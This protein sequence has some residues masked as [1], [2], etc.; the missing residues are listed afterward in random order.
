MAYR[1]AIKGMVC[2]RCDLAL[3]ELAEATGAHVLDSGRGYVDFAERLSTEAERAFER[4][5]EGI[6]F[7]ILRSETEEVAEAVEQ[8]L[9]ELVRERPS[10]NSASDLSRALSPKLDLPFARAAALYQS[11]R[12]QTPFER[13]TELRMQ[14]ATER[15]REGRMQ[16]S[17]VGY[18]LGY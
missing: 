12:S 14:W 7:S 16:V 6:R 13:F 3:A 1:Y 4:A 18:A 15:L 8:L 10:L 11:A 17:E 5:L 2:H 9:Q